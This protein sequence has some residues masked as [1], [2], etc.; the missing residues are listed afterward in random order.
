ML[1]Q[2]KASSGFGHRWAQELRIAQSVKREHKSPQD[3][4]TCTARDV[5]LIGAGSVD[6]NAQSY[7]MSQQ[8]YSL[9]AQACN[10]SEMAA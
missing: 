7:I 6:N 5:N 1:I 8:G 10:L 3:A 9:A 2:M 4:I